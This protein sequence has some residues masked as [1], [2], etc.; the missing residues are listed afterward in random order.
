VYKLGS[1]VSRRDE[2]EIIREVKEHKDEVTIKETEILFT[3][4]Y[5][6]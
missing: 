2:K 6:I 5:R 3:Y 4:M 1:C